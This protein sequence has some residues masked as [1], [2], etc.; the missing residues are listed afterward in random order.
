[1]TSSLRFAHFKTLPVN[2]PPLL[3]HGR[4]VGVN[5]GRADG[6]DL[7]DKSPKAEPR[8]GQVRPPLGPALLLRR[9]WVHVHVVVDKHVEEQIDLVDRQ[10]WNGVALDAEADQLNRADFCAERSEIV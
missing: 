3:L 8:R 5:D 7:L 4:A 6:V 10:Q 9:V 2:R 1:M